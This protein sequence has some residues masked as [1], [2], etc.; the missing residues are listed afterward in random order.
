[1]FSWRTLPSGVPAAGPLVVAHRGSSRRAPENTMAAFRLAIA[2]G[3]P[4]FELDAR[5]TS[6]RRVV[7][8]HDS[9]L[10]RTAGG[11]GRVS[12]SA[13]AAIRRLSAGAWFSPGFAGER[14]PF[15]EEVLDLAAGRIGVNVELKFDSRLQDPAPLVRAVSA[16][17]RDFP[18]PGSVLVSSFHHPS[19]A[20]QKK[21]FPAA[22]TG[23]LVYP[24]G[25][26]STSGRRLAARLGAGWLIY[27]GG[28][29]RKSFVR[30][31]HEDGLRVLEYTVSGIMGLKRAIAMGVDGVITDDPAGMIALQERRG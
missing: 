8:F 1:M 21:L 11:R 25:C 6:D 23:M 28:N 20:L 9:T 7:V 17:L 22:D 14:V 4:A 10:S 31:A 24:P 30:R 5:L 3:A 19:L 15:L 18:H 13:S 2:G 16:I 29:I 12:L 26:P 27:S